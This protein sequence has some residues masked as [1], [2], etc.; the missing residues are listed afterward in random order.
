MAE[1]KTV[2]HR[3]NL[4]HGHHRGVGDYHGD[5]PHAHEPVYWGERNSRTAIRAIRKAGGESP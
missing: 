1:V 2:S 4:E 3:L 5:I